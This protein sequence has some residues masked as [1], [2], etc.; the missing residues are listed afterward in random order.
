MLIHFYNYAKYYDILNFYEK[1]GFEQI[2]SCIKTNKKIKYV[3]DPITSNIIILT[4]DD[5]NYIQNNFPFHRLIIINV[6]DEIF[7]ENNVI[8]NNNKII[9]VLDHHK[10]NNSTDENYNKKIL[11][12]L[13]FGC[14]YKKVYEENTIL[15]LIKNRYYDVVFLGSIKY[16]EKITKHRKDTIDNILKF[17]NKHNYITFK[18]D[19]N[20]CQIDL[21]NFYKIIKNTKIFISP[22]GW[23][24]WSLKEYECICLGCHVMV[25]N[26]CLSSYPNYYEDFDNFELDFSNFEN[27]LLNLLS[28][29][30]VVQEKVNNNRKKFINFD[31][32]DQSE[33]LLN[34]LIKDN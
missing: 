17:C 32:V 8:F 5:L 30:D 33:Y 16:N 7:T 28:N 24:E 15:P 11:P 26:L 21:N 18:P 25:P 10:I 12:I 6:H 20:M 34:F 2:L 13:N 31:N 9:C 1:E 23:G 22:F 19:N 14:L 4:I 3:D 27:K 29:L